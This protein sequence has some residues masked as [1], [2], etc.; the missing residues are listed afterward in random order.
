MLAKQWGKRVFL[1]EN[2]AIADDS[3]EKEAKMTVLFRLP[4]SRDEENHVPIREN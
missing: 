2:K 4:S 1:W 3:T